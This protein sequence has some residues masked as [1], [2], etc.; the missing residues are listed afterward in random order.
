MNRYIDADKLCNDRPQCP[1]GQSQEYGKCFWDCIFKFSELIRKH[2]N[3]STADVVEVVR[4]RDCKHNRDNG[5][6]CDRTIILNEYDSTEYRYAGLE[7][8][9]YGERKEENEE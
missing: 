3:N 2:I 8:C 9:S 6:D 5:G 1:R 4:C 7:Y